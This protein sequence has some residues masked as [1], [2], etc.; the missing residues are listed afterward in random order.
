M[1]KGKEAI[2]TEPELPEPCQSTELPEQDQ[3]T[4]TPPLTPPLVSPTV[5]KK[6]SSPNL[7]EGMTKY[8]SHQSGSQTYP[9]YL[10]SLATFIIYYC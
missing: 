10:F 3:S 4:E 2:T 6:S 7:T 8:F 9:T 5:E 1:I